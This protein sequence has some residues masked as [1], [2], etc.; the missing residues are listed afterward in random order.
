MIALPALYTTLFEHYGPRHWWPA[1]TPFEM[2]VGAILT[3]NTNWSRVEAALDILGREKLAPE[4]LLAMS[5]NQLAEAIRTS[6]YH[7]QKAQYLKTMAC[8]VIQS[9]GLSA[10]AEMESEALRSALLSLKG[11]GFETATSIL[12]YA[13]GRPYFVVDAYTRRLFGRM[14]YDFPAGYEPLRCWIEKQ[15]SPDI[16]LYNEFHAQIVFHSKTH[17]MA[18]PVCENCPVEPYCQK[19]FTN[20]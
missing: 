8:W 19:I 18:K 1:E 15:I 4:T 11:V 5:D 14:G 9:G 3:Q 6:G 20:K 12:L 16:G 13:F 10:I 17:C 7:R 2:M